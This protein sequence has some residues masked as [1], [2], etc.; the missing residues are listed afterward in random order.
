[1]S[2]HLYQEVGNST[3]LTETKLNSMST[4]IND[5]L[6]SI[7]DVTDQLLSSANGALKFADLRNC[8]SNMVQQGGLHDGE[9][10][11]IVSLFKDFWSPLLGSLMAEFRTEQQGLSITGVSE[12]TFQSSIPLHRLKVRGN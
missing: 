6:N 4:A 5:T 11:V 10:C 9:S 12:V 1:M 3:R 8:L 7:N 2:Y